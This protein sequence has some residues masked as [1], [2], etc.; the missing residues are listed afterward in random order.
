MKN[1]FRKTI[2]LSNRLNP[3]QARR[4]SG[5]IWVQSVCR[6]C[7]QTT[8]VGNELIPSECQTDWIQI[9]HD[10]LSGLIWFQSVCKG[11]QQKT[12][13]GNELIC[14]HCVNGNP[15]QLAS[16]EFTKEEIEFWK[17]NMSIVGLLV[18]I[19]YFQLFFIWNIFNL[20]YSFRFFSFVI[21]KYI[22]TEAKMRLFFSTKKNVI[23]L[24]FF[25]ENICCGSLVDASNGHPPQQISQLMILVLITL[26]S[27][28]GTDKSVQMQ[29]L[30]RACT[31]HITKYRHKRAT[32]C[33]TDQY[34]FLEEGKKLVLDCIFTQKAPPIICS[35]QQFQI[36]LIFQK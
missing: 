1:S 15:D 6:G 10:I 4:L 12:L 18:W 24:L 9:R 8:L 11:Y 29:S 28:Q 27:D 30:A 14:I 23:F 33:L 5:L 21:F 17:T 34:I 31:A 7:Q 36:L 22:L 32:L 20:V 13:V 35:R 3:D 26:V 16:D 19:W 25:Y 2:W